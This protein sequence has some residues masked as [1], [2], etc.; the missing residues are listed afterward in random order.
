MSATTVQL[1]Q[2]ASEVVGGEAAL[3][4]ELG[5]GQTLLARFM[6]DIRELP[7]GLLLRAVDIILADRQSRLAP[8]PR[9]GVLPPGAEISENLPRGGDGTATDGGA[10]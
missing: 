6:E 4:R 8:R 3:A 1:L 7:D 10:G 2:A 9:T 5:I